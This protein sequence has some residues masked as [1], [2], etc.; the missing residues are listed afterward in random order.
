MFR[1]PYMVTMRRSRSISQKLMRRRR[2]DVP[3]EEESK[4]SDMFDQFNVVM[5]AARCADD[6]TIMTAYLKRFD[7][8]R[9]NED[10]NTPLHIAA[11]H[12]HA[13]ICRLLVVLV[14]PV[15]IWEVRNN[16]GL[17]AEDL[18]TDQSVKEDLR[19]LRE[20]HPREQD[21][22]SR[23]NDKLIENTKK[24]KENGKV[25]LALDGGGMK[26]LVILQIL[27]YLEKQLNGDLLSRIDW[28][29]GTSS[30]GIVALMLCQGDDK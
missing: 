4:D 20:R 8:T 1:R 19:L 12:G 18:A 10:G 3:D 24:W 15:R 30:G 14:S 28:I 23:F 13:N 5:N 16:S 17:T 27:L 25:L 29:A 2:K 26:A 6:D 7:L 22:Y 21:E 9:V 11:M